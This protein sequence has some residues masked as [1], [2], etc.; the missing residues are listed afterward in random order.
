MELINRDYKFIRSKNI[1]CKSCKSK[2]CVEYQDLKKDRRTKWGK[3]RKYYFV[4]SKCKNKIE[5][6]LKKA[7]KLK[8]YSS[9]LFRAVADYYNGLHFPVIKTN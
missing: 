5:F 6:S 8:P 7:E 2:F 9:K 4:C 1:K 3:V